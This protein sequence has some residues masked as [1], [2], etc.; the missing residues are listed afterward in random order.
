MIFNKLSKSIINKGGKIVI[1]TEENGLIGVLQGNRAATM[2]TVIYLREDMT[3][4]EVLEERKHFFQNISGKF[5]KFESDVRIVKQEIEANEY[6]L[7]V[8]DKF[9]IPLE[10]IE[11]TKEL[12]EYYQKC[13]IEIEKEGRWVE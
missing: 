7:S 2:D 8:K 4:S 13:K 5:D 1:A 3:I 9:K 6:L 10:E 11:E 12:L